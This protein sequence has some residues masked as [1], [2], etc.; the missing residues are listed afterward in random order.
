MKKLKAI[1]NAIIVVSIFLAVN[2]IAMGALQLAHQEPEETIPAMEANTEGPALSEEKTEP[3]AEK[4]ALGQ[5][6]SELRLTKIVGNRTDGIAYTYGTVM[7]SV[8]GQKAEELFFYPDSKPWYKTTYE[9]NSDGSLASVTTTG[10]EDGTVHT[11][12]SR[13]DYYEGG[14]MVYGDLTLYQNNQITQVIRDTYDTHGNTV[15]SEYF[16]EKGQSGGKSRIENTYDQYGNLLEAKSTF[17]GIAGCG[18]T[19]YDYEYDAA[20]RI[21]SKKTTSHAWS[22]TAEAIEN[23][24]IDYTV[25]ETYQ[26]DSRGNV[27]EYIYS[28]DAPGSSIWKS[29]Y[30]YWDND[31]CSTWKEYYDDE[32]TAEYVYVYDEYELPPS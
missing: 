30:T 31:Q 14:K 7:Y 16:D 1:R 4:P 15:E 32:L 9:Y 26:Y 10:F 12:Y 5:T 3:A 23:K 29:E 19:G 13:T 27:T 8:N 28:T 17:E 25:T 24:K 2:L 21:L 18:F 20:G 6:E 11:E 22:D